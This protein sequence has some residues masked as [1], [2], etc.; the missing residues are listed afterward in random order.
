MLD[1][2]AMLQPCRFSR[3][4]SH[5]SSP[6]AALQPLRSPRSWNADSVAAHLVPILQPHAGKTSKRP[7]STTWCWIQN[8]RK[9]KAT[10]RS[11]HGSC[12]G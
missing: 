8:R 5:R 4:P 6:A 12:W 9:H 1:P 7:S 11:S 10:T 3:C 2:T